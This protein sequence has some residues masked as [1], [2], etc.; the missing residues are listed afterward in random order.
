MTVCYRCV[1]C[2]FV[3]WWRS[4]LKRMSAVQE[5]LELAKARVQGVS[6]DRKSYA[7]LLQSLMV[8][9]R[10]IACW[11]VNRAPWA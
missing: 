6:A 4:L 9:V 7:S 2:S 10:S 8:Q 5:V 3:W 1:P 11:V